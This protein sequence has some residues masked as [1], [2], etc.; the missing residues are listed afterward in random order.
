MDTVRQKAQ[1]VGLL[2]LRVL[3]GLGIAYHGFGKVFGVQDGVP[4]IEGLTKAVEAMGF[5][6]PGLFAWAA[7]LS[8]FLGGVLIVLGLGTRGAALFVLVTMLDAA[9]VRHGADPFK[10]RELAL[11][12]GT[13]AA[14]LVL[15]GAG[16]LSLDA[17]IL[18]KWRGKGGERKSDE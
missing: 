5:P 2:W 10:V 9:F 18:N 4:V 11:A 3:M 14:A 1:A 16:S 13:V 17:L 7:A 8:E 15:T 6:L 12:Y